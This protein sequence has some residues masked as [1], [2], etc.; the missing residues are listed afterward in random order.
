MKNITILSVLFFSFG[1]SC[2]AQKLNPVLFNKINTERK[3][4]EI[5]KL[6][7]NYFE[8]ETVQQRTENNPQLLLKFEKEKKHWYRWLWWA[9]H[10]TDSAGNILTDN[11]TV[12]SKLENISDFQNQ[13]SI[14]AYASNSGN[15]S[16]IGPDGVEKGLARVDR[17]A[18]HPTDPLQLY[19]GT[20]AG[21][22]WKSNNGGDNWYELNG[23]Q[24]QFGVSGVVVDQWNPNTIYA[25]TGEFINVLYHRKCYGVLKSTDGGATWNLKNTIVTGA[26][27]EAD[28]GYRLIQISSSK[29]LAST[30]SG[31]FIT[32][33]G[34]ETWVLN[35]VLRYEEMVKKPGSSNIV[36][37]ANNHTIFKSTN[38][39]DSYVQIPL[40]NLNS[41]FVNYI[42]GN[43]KLAVTPAN[44]SH[45]TVQISGSLRNQNQST[46]EINRIYTSYNEGA[47]W[48]LKTNSSPGVLKEFYAAMGIS[49]TN[50]NYLFS[51]NVSLVQS[52]DGGSTYGPLYDSDQGIHSDHHEILPNPIDHKMYFC[53][54]GG[55]YKASDQSTTFSFKST[56]VLATQV[57][58]I[59]GTNLDDNVFVCGTQDNGVILKKS[60][61]TSA[62]VRGGDGFHL[63]FLNNS[64][65]EFIFN[66][67]ESVF[68]YTISTQQ[69]LHLFT[70]QGFNGYNPALEIHPTNNNIIYLGYTNGL[71]RSDNGGLTFNQINNYTI[72]PG[73]NI[74]SGGLA[75]SA[76][77]PD[78]I[79]IS[80]YGIVYRSDNRGATSVVISQNSGWPAAPGNISDICTRPNNADEI[81]VTFT[82]GNVIYSSNAG[83]TWTD[84]TGSLPALPIYCIQYTSSGDAY[85]G[86]EAGVYYMG[87]TM[88][89]WAP[90]YNGLPQLPV[91]DLFINENAATIKAAT[92]GRGVWKSDLY[93]SCA[94]FL[95]L[96]GVTN[97]VNF[98]QADGIINSTQV[99]EGSYGNDIKYR[100]P[101]QIVFL[102]GFNAKAG[103][104]LQTVIGSCGQ[105]VFRKFGAE[106]A[107][108]PKKLS[109][110]IETK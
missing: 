24:P 3:L 110:K 2:V 90:F 15:W 39:G 29:L 77:M 63:K 107:A 71:Y 56:G 33:N 13:R 23:F 21:G 97:G 30:S 101:S 43:I 83:L 58:R 85:I 4:V 11:T 22:L 51:G 66:T 5:V 69:L 99:I 89:D 9:M 54:D 88:N 53:T 27:I 44:P 74:P 48:V 42:S 10:H 80:N 55:V 109:S 92:F 82:S 45:L 78:R 41:D 104:S 7:T 1:Y 20:P 86:T 8:V 25:L 81:W 94:P 102:P 68:K 50:E 100:S 73:F 62:L 108:E 31:Y 52:S 14:E 60:N 98:Y 38:G 12:T 57:Y 40:T 36:Y 95:N 16:C 46:T 96:A 6:A 79:Y 37:A 17:I 19:C 26:T 103:S 75:V 106:A 34:G 105:G 84:L 93:A 49:S 72:S 64:A 47:S 61:G 76:H 28:L 67:N 59:A 91:T 70:V 35:S 87:L 18:F 32:N 65:N